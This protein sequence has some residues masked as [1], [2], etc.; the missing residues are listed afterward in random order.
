MPKSQ[1]F[2]VIGAVQYD[3][4]TS[5]NK[6]HQIANWFHNHYAHTEEDATVEKKMLKKARTTGYHE[7]G[8][9]V[10]VVSRVKK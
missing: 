9:K 10:Y 4:T 1:P 2:C 6:P 5:E 8:D 7:E 3:V